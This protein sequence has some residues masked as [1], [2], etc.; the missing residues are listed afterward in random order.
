[1]SKNKPNSEAL[2]RRDFVKH[3]IAASSIFIVPRH[4][5]G[6]LGYTAPS[7]QLGLAAIGAGG[8]GASDIR[9]ASVDGRERVVALC[10]VDSSGGNGISRSIKKFSDA[11]FY[12]NFKK[13]LDK[14]KDIDAVTISTPD[15]T[16]AAAAVYAMER[17]IHVYVQKPL[18]HNIYE[19]RLLT[20]MAREKQ[21]V[22]QMGN[23]GA[24]N[25]EQ[26]QIQKWI[27]DGRIGKISKIEIWTNRPVWPQGGKMPTADASAKPEGFNWDQWLGPAQE[28]PFIPNMHPFNWRGWWNFGTGALG[29]MGCHLIDIPFKALGLKY[30]KDVECSV[31][32]VYEKMWTANYY[33]EGCPPSSSVSLHFDP[34]EKNDIPIQMTWSDGGIKPFHPDLLPADVPIEA[35]GVLMIGEKGVI[36]CDAYGEDA[37]LYIKN[38]AVIESEKTKVNEPEFGHQRQWVDACKAGFNSPEHKALTSSFDYSGPLTETVLMG[39]IAIRSYLLRSGSGRDMKFIGRKKLLWDGEAMKIKNLEAANQFVGRAYRKGWELT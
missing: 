11:K 21:I 6:G 24:S 13:M 34:T 30:P 28:T 16:H 17:G 1:M 27:Q 12:D 31:G 32:S 33:P 36:S 19:A 37:K 9:N 8:K 35:N 15:H 2:K 29:D 4:V 38:E 39:N 14:E 20:E 23:Q 10:D 7:D 3:S 5:L 18:T 22:S 25:P 26:L